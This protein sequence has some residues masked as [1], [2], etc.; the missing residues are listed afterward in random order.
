MVVVLQYQQ[1]E[2]MPSLVSRLA[3]IIA[4][5]W[6]LYSVKKDA[7]PIVLGLFFTITNY[8]FSYSYM[9]YEVYQYDVMIAIGLIVGYNKKTV[10]DLKIPRFLIVWLV[11]ITSVDVILSFQ[12]N[13]ISYSILGIILLWPY[14]E[15]GDEKQCKL[16]SLGIILTGFVLALNFIVFGNRYAEQYM[17]DATGLNREGWTDP[18]YFGCAVGMGI[19]AAAVELV[20][21]RFNI[22]LKAIFIGAIVVMFACL[23]INASRGAL[24]SIACSCTLIISLAKI[25]TV[26]KVLFVIGMI[27]TV[28]A[29]DNL[30]Y[31]ELLRYRIEHDN[32][33][34]S[35][36]TIIWM[37]KLEAFFDQGNPFYYFLGMGQEG[38]RDLAQVRLVHTGF[39]N[40]F[41][42]FLCEYGL[43]G[44][45]LYCK[46]LYFPISYS[47]GNKVLIIAVIMYIAVCSSTLEPITAGRFTYFIFWLYALQLATIKKSI[48]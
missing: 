36:R 7:M 24:L 46:W 43:I 18:N 22:I 38:G 8:N 48:I 17:G 19:V 3:Y 44:L 23:A 11:L 4:V 31:F 28:I 9:P 15:Y 45:Y 21:K 34:G 47:Q 10:I 37:T 20:Y 30:G 16:M 2:V 5:M 25:K 33:G 13:Y 35:G 14:I 12:I 41:I 29:L 39:H 42:A 40:D 27:G 26:Y 32:N 1:S 6:P